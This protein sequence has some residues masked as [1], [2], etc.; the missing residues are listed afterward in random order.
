MRILI[1][2][3][4]AVLAS[5]VPCAAF[6][7][8][9]RVFQT[10]ESQPGEKLAPLVNTEPRLSFG[11]V[12]NLNANAPADDVLSPTIDESA[13]FLT[14]VS[15][16]FGPQSVWLSLLFVPLDRDGDRRPDAFAYAIRI[17]R[18]ALAEPPPDAP[19][20]VVLDEGE[21][22]FDGNGR[23]ADP[24]AN[25]SFIPPRLANGIPATTVWWDLYDDRGRGL[26]TRRAAPY[27]VTASF[28]AI[29]G[30]KVRTRGL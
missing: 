21:L 4:V 26:L 23:L 25:F 1:R 15:A 16:E 27:E 8:D 24:P 22:L 29:N 10:F 30:R 18:E 6:A 9:E 20:W 14:G 17:E 11:I 7:Q 13:V 5:F 19:W 3:L 12:A 2:T 28:T